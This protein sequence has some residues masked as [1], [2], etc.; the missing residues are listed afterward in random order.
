MVQ[1]FQ[2]E[3]LV[4]QDL[5][6]VVFRAFDTETG[7]TVALHRF[8][9]FGIDGGG[10]HVDEESAYRRALG[11]LTGL[12]HPAL[13]SVIGGGCDPVDGMPYIATEWV[14]GVPL[15]DILAHGPLSASAA[16]GLI[17][18]ALEV[19]E[20]LSQLLGEEAVWVAT[21]LQS[22]IE[23]SENARGFTFWISPLTWLG[24]NPSS[25][26]LRPIVTLTEELLGWKGRRMRDQAGGGLGGWLNWLRQAGATA[27]LGEARASLAAVLGQGATGPTHRLVVPV[28]RRRALPDRAPAATRLWAVILALACV[29]TG[30]GGWLL[31]LR[32]DFT[33]PVEFHEPTVTRPTEPPPTSNHSAPPAPVRPDDGV[34]HWS[35]HEALTQIDNQAAV[36]EGVLAKIDFSYRKK[37]LY[38]LFSQAPGK[39]DARGAVVRKSA[40]SD[41]SESALAPLIGKKV[42]LHGTVKV[43][44]GVGLERPDILVKNRSAIEIIQ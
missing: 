5:S 27:S 13:R 40:A 31:V 19:S 2:I 9:P 28:A 42:R 12:R 43:Q 14:E 33:P 24:E 38:L 41:L 34:I 22:I 16:T 15:K 25:R 1:R 36:V 10:L 7:L 11:R 37:T 8:F 17:D 21:E 30:L 18:Q 23:S 4:S 32:H 29:A 3:D 20:L 39:N 44:K 26:G 35:Q 6:G